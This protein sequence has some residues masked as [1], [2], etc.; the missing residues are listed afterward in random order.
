MEEPAVP[1]GP[2]HHRG[3]AELMA[4]VVH[5]VC[6][7]RRIRILQIIG[8]TEV[9]NLDRTCRNAIAT[10]MRQEEICRIEWPRCRYENSPAIPGGISIR[11][12]GTA[13]TRTRSGTVVPTEIEKLTLLTRAALLVST[14]WR[15]LVR[16]SSDKVT[17]PPPWPC[18]CAVPCRS[19]PTALRTRQTTLSLHGRSGP[20]N[21]SLQC[22]SNTTCL[23]HISQNKVS[24]PEPHGSGVVLEPDEPSRLQIIRCAGRR[25]SCRRRWLCRLVPSC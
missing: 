11:V 9:F 14:V 7:F 24:T 10:A 13:T 18:C 6:I 1:V 23:T 25:R 22:D 3:N 4:Q 8:P 2:V 12:V 20:S 5:F 19:C 21:L 16:C 15:I 17:L